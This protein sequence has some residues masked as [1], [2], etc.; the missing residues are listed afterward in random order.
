MKKIIGLILS[1]CL[2]FVGMVPAFAADT[3]SSYT[4]AIDTLTSLNILVGNDKGEL[5]L[6]S[7][8]TRAEFSTLIIRIL[9][10][11]DVAKDVSVN[12]VFF[13]VPASHWA[14][15]YV[16][17]ANQQGI[18]VGYGDGTFGPED[19]VTYEQAV[20]MIVCALGY[21][22]KFT[23][24][25]NAYPSA[26]LSQANASGITVGATGKIGE[27]ATR[28]TVAKLIYNAL[29]I[30]L[31]EQTGFGS[32]DKFEEVNKTLL[33][34]KLNIIKVEA[35]VETLFF[36]PEQADEVV[37][38]VTKAAD[39]YVEAVDADDYDNLDG[40]YEYAEGVK[41]QKGYNCVAYIDISE[42]NYVIKAM[43]PKA[44]K[45]ATLVLTGVQTKDA[46]ITGLSEL[47]Y[48]KNNSDIDSTPTKI[49]TN[50]V[51][52]FINK[53]AEST[54]S[55]DNF[56]EAWNN[57]DFEEITLIDNGNDNKYDYIYVSNCESWVVN[58]IK[59]SRNR[60][61]G[62]DNKR[63]VLD[64]EDEENTFAI[65]D[66][67]GN[68]LDF[69]D[70][71]IGDV[72]N[73]FV[74]TDAEDKTLTEVI[75]TNET[76]EGTITE[77]NN[78]TGKVTIGN[79]EYNNTIFEVGDSGEFIIDMYGNIIDY[80]IDA[81]N[82]KFG[83]IYTIYNDNSEFDKVPTA[84][85]LTAEGKFKSYTFAKKVDFNGTEY[86]RTEMI[87][88][89]ADVLELGAYVLNSSNEITKLYTA[90]NIAELDE[91]YTFAEKVEN[92]E[93]DGAAEDINNLYVDNSSIILT[94]K[95]ADYTTEDRAINYTAASKSYF[96]DE[97]KYTFEAIT[98]DD[99]I[100]I[101]MVF[102]AEAQVDKTTMAM[103]VTSV[104]DTT[105]S[106]GDNAIKVK[107]YV[108][109]ELVSIIIP[110]D[111]DGNDYSK[112]KV[113]SMIQYLGEDEATALKV[114]VE[115]ASEA[116]DLKVG[117]DA[118]E[119]YYA[120]AGK[121][122]KIAKN[123]FYFEDGTTVSFAAGTPA[124]L[125]KENGKVFANDLAAGDIDTTEYLDNEVS[126]DTLILYMYDG[127]AI[128]AIIYDANND[129]EI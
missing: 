75:V 34:S 91:D 9:G 94:V 68:E 93:Y 104:S 6:D 51:K 79:K 58:E 97:E 37:I 120:Y 129:T 72:L 10:M 78:T 30:K 46:G 18:I 77:K 50:D 52:I 27:K 49:K 5:N 65:T 24:V 89:A 4:E 87:D 16:H 113:G 48:Y 118:K 67:N 70:I 85:I 31:M 96:V 73:I 90:A 128:G 2:M 17:T 92:K 119:G 60:I 40:T 83:M 98:E 39:L 12:T 20:K 84:L 28:G 19:E 127:D 103:Y 45:N 64:P 29:D 109:G 63:I 112:V 100:I 82:R 57:G 7:T 22:I 74:S 15:G 13:D 42:D 32:E 117:D 59:E 101:A 47:K 1:F 107:G 54:M 25:E 41:L 55:A 123:K 43:V 38:D 111:I 108:D 105:D 44:G 126:D 116:L 26:Y 86:T 99:E 36:N 69:S 66:I 80:V 95:T 122:K 3:N 62:K 121:V 33:S 14:S 102:G 124:M 23:G 114:L 35:T 76:V 11:E 71:R 61:N 110:E 53:D 21:G 56:I 8:I 115:K 125:V 88:K 81:S 106:E